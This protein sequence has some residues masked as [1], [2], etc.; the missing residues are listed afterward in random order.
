MAGNGAAN[1]HAVIAA[2]HFQFVDG[3]FGCEVDE[4]ADLVYGHGN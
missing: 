3:G 4:L 2:L 1:A